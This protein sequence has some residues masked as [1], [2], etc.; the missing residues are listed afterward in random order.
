MSLASP[1][2]RA[3]GLGS[4]G[5]GTQDWWQQRVTAI[6][7]LPLSLWFIGSLLALDYADPA[8]VAGWLRS[9]LSAILMLMFVLVLLHHAQLGVQVVIEDYVEPEWQKVACV[10]LVKFLAVLVGLASALAILK[11]FFGF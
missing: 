8:A 11:V 10:I 1:L 4:A 6:A 9:P 2:A 5:R 3:R 7:L